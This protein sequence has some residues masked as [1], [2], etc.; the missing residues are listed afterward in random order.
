MNSKFLTLI[1]FFVT[2]LSFGVVAEAKSA[3]TISQSRYNKVCK[4]GILNPPECKK[5]IKKTI[6]NKNKNTTNI[7]K[8]ATTTR[9][10][11]YEKEVV[12]GCGWGIFNP[13][14]CRG[15]DRRVKSETRDKA[16]K[17]KK[18]TIKTKS[19]AEEN[20]NISVYT[21]TFDILDKEGDDQTTLIGAEHKNKD[22]FRDTWLGRFSPTTGAFVTGKSS[23][24]LYTGI[25][26]EYNLGPIN[27]SPSFAPG[28]YEAGDGKN[29]GSAL[30]FKSEVK[31]GIDLLKGA[32]L[33][34][35]YS[36]I[37]NNEWGDVNPGTDN[38]SLTF[39]KNF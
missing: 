1:F 25:E 10:N 15:K 17:E 39:S 29:L 14:K 27:I 13:P 11:N 23:I 24:Y 21:G 31:I 6:S 33:G 3:E 30:E 5:R 4:W 34:Y 9:D 8:Q 26:A 16:Y 7:S 36:H 32:N 35:S 20:Q 28:Y 19:F 18:Q 2:L 37:S 22:L 12:P 38:Q